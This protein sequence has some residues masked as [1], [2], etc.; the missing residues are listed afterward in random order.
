MAN[1]HSLDL[2]SASSQYASAADSASLS[3][4]GDI[5][6]EAWVKLESAIGEEVVAKWNDSATNDR[7]YTLS[8]N[9]SRRFYFCTSGNGSTA[10]CGANTSTSAV[11]LGEWHH[12]AVTY[13]AVAG[14]CA[15]YLDGVADGTE[16]GLQ[17]SL[18]NSDKPLLIGAQDSATPEAFF[19]G[20]IDEIRIW[21]DIRTAQEILD[22]K[23]VELV[24]NEANLQAY[25]KL[26]NGYTD[27]TAN[28]NTLTATG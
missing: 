17:T 27:E 23:S 19:D 8:L 25:W 13:N 4:T 9:T 2:E 24:G 26:N 7:C 28:A 16:T 6:I 1:T 14:T 20:L 10:V 15:Y 18:F 21:N 3:I 22:N 5:T 12:I 11:P